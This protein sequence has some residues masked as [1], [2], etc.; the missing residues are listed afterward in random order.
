V[1]LSIVG[2]VGKMT[3]ERA[4]CVNRDWRGLVEMAKA[5]G[6][7]KSKP[8]VSVAAG[9]THSG[10]TVKVFTFAHGIFGRL[11]HGGQQKELVPR[12]VLALV[13]RR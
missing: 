7:Y 10:C 11:G 5:L 1:L 8:L 6:M 12:L 4:A 2:Q 13:G 3:G 9:G